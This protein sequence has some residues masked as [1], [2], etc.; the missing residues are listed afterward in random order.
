M[1]ETMHFVDERA[2][3][4][5]TATYFCETFT[6]DMHSFYLLSLLLTADHDK[7]EQCFISAMGECVEENGV[8]REWA[9]S[10][11]R[12]AILKHAIKM[13]MPVPED[14]V[15]LS[16]ISFK[17]PAKPGK[18]NLCGAIL[19]LS[20]FE[21]FVFVMSVLE[22]QFDEECALLLRC[23]PC[24]VMMARVLALKRLA[25]TDVAYAQAGEVLQA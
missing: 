11:A 4:Y 2:T 22:G 21:R 13:I 1:L 12:R 14:A 7:A 5:A 24:D 17:G 18:N 20:A 10:W 3:S 23:L 6:D 8:C 16:P 19:A 15:H 25:N 9:P